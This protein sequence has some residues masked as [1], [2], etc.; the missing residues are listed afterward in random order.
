MVEKFNGQKI[1]AK[2]QIHKDKSDFPSVVDE[3]ATLRISMDKKEFTEINDSLKINYFDSI[4]LRT[5][6]Y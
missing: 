5:F 3:F 2:V 6:I 1:Y 4:C